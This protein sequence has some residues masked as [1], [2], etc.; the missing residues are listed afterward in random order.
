MPALVGAGG[1]DRATELHHGHEQ[2][3]PARVSYADPPGASRLGFPERDD[4]SAGV[5]HRGSDPRQPQPL[6][7]SLGDPTLREPGRIHAAGHP[8]RVEPATRKLTCH[9]AASQHLGQARRH[10]REIE[11]PA[12]EPAQS[13]LGLPGA[14]LAIG[15]VQGRAGRLQGGASRAL[16]Q[17]PRAQVERHDRAHHMLGVADHW[18]ADATVPAGSWSSADWSEDR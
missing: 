14:E 8:P 2:V 4:V 7:G 18:L 5:D 12:A 13:A 1:R 10:V 11:L 16:A 17:V 3:G 9:R 15:C 6:E